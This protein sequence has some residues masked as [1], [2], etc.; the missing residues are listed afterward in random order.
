[1]HL[2]IT[3]AGKLQG[4]I[5][6]WSEEHSISKETIED[7]S[8]E[9]SL[10]FAVIVED[11]KKEFPPTDEAP[12]HEQRANMTRVALNRTQEKFVLVLVKVGMAQDTA[13]ELSK[14]FEELIPYAEKVIITAG[15]VYE[16]G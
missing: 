10:R 1:M 8:T 13:E 16:P 2:A 4:K 6:K 9:L 5:R 7:I 11:L 14:D 3:W 12:G 15:K